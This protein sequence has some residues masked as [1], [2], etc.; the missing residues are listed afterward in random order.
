YGVLAATTLARHHDGET[1]PFYVCENGFI[2]VNPLP[3]GAR[4]GSLSTRTAHPVF[5]KQVQQIIDAAG[6]RVRIEPLSAHDKGRD[7]RPLCRPDSPQSRGLSIDKLRAVSE[8]QL[9]ALRSVRA[10]TVHLPW[11][12]QVPGGS[13]AVRL[14]GHTR[15]F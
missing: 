10:V 5:L 1:V 3:T 4:I 7:A 14:S 15:R 11:V 13:L 8:V 2:A 6:L 9:Q 12:R